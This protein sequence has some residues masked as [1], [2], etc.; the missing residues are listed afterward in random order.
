MGREGQHGNMKDLYMYISSK[1]KARGNVHLLL[2][3]AEALVTKDT[4]NAK[5]L[6]DFF[7]F[8]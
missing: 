4:G 5:L 1:L 7:S 2:N 6:N 8:L 3:G